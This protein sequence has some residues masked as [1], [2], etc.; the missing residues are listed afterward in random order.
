MEICGP[1]TTSSIWW[2]MQY[3]V[4]QKEY[5]VDPIC[6]HIKDIHVN[7]DHNIASSAY[8]STKIQFYR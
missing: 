8:I 6:K 5:K 3:L 7:A 4:V 2:K 1:K